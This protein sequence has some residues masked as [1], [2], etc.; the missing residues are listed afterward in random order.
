MSAKVLAA[1]WSL[2]WSAYAGW[3]TTWSSSVATISA[4]ST[5]IISLF[6]DRSE[7]LN[8]WLVSLTDEWIFLIETDTRDAVMHIKAYRRC[9]LCRGRRYGSCLFVLLK[10]AK[11]MT[12]AWFSRFLY[13]KWGLLSAITIL[14]IVAL[15]ALIA[16]VWKVVKCR[17]VEVLLVKALR[18][19]FGLIAPVVV[20]EGIIV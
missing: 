3:S 14:S 15:V 10:V 9:R 20:I 11:V 17:V 8:F 1:V 16:P 12:K 7:R 19:L 2:V 18:T 6:A 5:T 13:A 4:K